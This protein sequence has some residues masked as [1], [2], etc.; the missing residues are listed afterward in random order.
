MSENYFNRIDEQQLDDDKLLSELLFS[1]SEIYHENSK[2][3]PSDKELYL[4]INSINSSPRIRHVISRPFANYSRNPS[5]KLPEQN[6][7]NESSSLEKAL[8]ERRSTYE[9]SGCSIN[10]NTLGKILHLG[11]G[12]V[13]TR[14]DPDGS[15]WSL[16]T[17]P[18]G[19]GLYPVNLYCISLTV[20]GLANG[21][22]FYNPCDHTLEQLIKK[23]LIENLVTA[24]VGLEKSIAQ[25][26]F[27]IILTGVMR[28][29]KFKYG[30][31]GY[32]F[33]LLEAGHIAQNFIL[34]SHL[35]GL[36]SIPIGGFI[37]DQLNNLLGL[38][39]VEE[40]VLYLVLIGC[41]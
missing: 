18:S 25:A 41:K 27:C 30:E 39:G 34:V 32:R 13:T 24:C 31:R 10:L 37:D 16:R 21:L 5:L 14:T 17:A 35:E 1:P 19:G 28:R 15:I 38:D 40:A 22:Y 4:N 2:L 7:L 11:D 29:S 12:I 33:I 23:D 8:I 6:L 9:F 20:D 3:H 36:G 26:S